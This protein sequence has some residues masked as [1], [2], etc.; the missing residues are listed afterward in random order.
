MSDVATITDVAAEVTDPA[1]QATLDEH[2]K[3]I[4]KYA[5]HTIEDLIEIGRRLAEVKKILG[6]TNWVPWLES[7]F[8]W[9]ETQAERFIALHDLR[10]LV[11]TVGDWDVPISGLYLLA[12]KTTPPEVIKA[13]AI[14]A[15]GGER[16]SVAEVK[17]TITKAKAKRK[18]RLPSY[19]PTRE[20]AKAGTK[21]SD[22]AVTPGDTALSDF[23]A[24]VLDLL[25]RI[26][27]HRPDRFAR[28]AAKAGDL[29]KLGKFLTGLAE[30]LK[31]DGAQ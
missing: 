7:E 11:P 20:A 13:V 15:E 2:A 16:V 1:Q 29:A 21:K 27:K 6:Y 30:L 25:R 17:A 24:R 8:A 19:I 23:T 3:A 28:T 5:K 14:K 9:S 12:G 10:R 22:K 18:P 31:A 26:A 4:R